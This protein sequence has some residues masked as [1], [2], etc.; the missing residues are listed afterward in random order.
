MQPTA[1]RGSHIDATTTQRDHTL[2]QHTSQ[3]GSYT[4]ATHSTTR[5]T[6]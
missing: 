2:V 3:R 6:H 5:I 1:Q 4:G